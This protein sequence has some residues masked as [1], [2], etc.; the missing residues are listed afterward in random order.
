MTL[1][2]EDASGMRV[3]NLV[4][5][6]PFPAGDNVA[7]W[8]GLDDVGRDTDAAAHATYHIPGKIVAP[9]AYRVR[10]LVRPQIDLRYEMTAYHSGNPPWLTK[11]RSS[12]WLANH[13]PPSAVLYVPEGAAPDRPGHPAPGGQVLVGS[14]VSEGG[15][16]LAWLNLDGKKLNGQEWVGGVWTGATQLARDEGEHPVP[17]VYAYT[18]SAWRG[19]KYNGNQPELRLHM[20]VNGA[21]KLKAPGDTRMGTGEDVPVL[22]PTYKLPPG[23]PDPEYTSVP[24]LGGLAVRNGILVAAITPLDELVFFDVAAGKAIATASIPQPRGLAFD[25]QGRLLAISQK[26]VVRIEMPRF[27]G[28]APTTQAVTLAAPQVIVAS[29]LDDPQQLT[30]DPQGNLYVSDRGDSHQVKVFSPEGKLLRAI[31]AKGPPSVGIYD[32]G[33][34][35]NPNGITIDGRGHLWVAETDNLPKRLSVWTMDGKLVAAF[36][37][38]PHYGGGGSIDPPDPSRFFYADSGGA[39]ELKLDWAK[40]TSAPL[41]VYLRPELDALKEFFRN[42]RSTGPETPVHIEGRTYLTDAYNSNPTGGISTASIWLLKGGRARPVATIGQANDWAAF[43]P[44]ARFSARWTGQ[45]VP[46]FSE[47]YTFTLKA[48]KG[49]RLWVNGKALIDDWRGGNAEATGTL[50]M[51]AGKRYDIRV[52]YFNSGGGASITLGWS[53][54]SQPKQAIPAA[55]LFP[56]DAPPDAKGGSGLSAEYFFDA[57]FKALAE[58]R[59]DPKVEFNWGNAGLKLAKAAPLASKLPAGVDLRKDHVLFA[60]SDLNDDGQ[61][62]PDEITCT[63]DDVLSVNVRQDLSAITGSGLLLKPTRFTPGGAPVYDAG[64]ARKVVEGTQRPTSSGGGQAVLGQ[65]GHFVFTNAPKPFSPNGIGGGKDGRATW[66]YPSLWPGLH[67]SHI[68]PVPEVPGELIGTTRLLGLPVT[69]R[70]SDLGAVW[71][72]NGNK[73][74][75][76]LFTTDGLFVAT[77]FKDSR[78]GSW[79]MPSADRG[80]LVNDA[81]IHEEDFFPSISQTVDGHIYLSV[82]NCCLVRVE[83][84]EKSHRLPDANITVSPEQLAEAQQ[85]FLA[86]EAARQEAARDKGPAE[87]TVA[88]RKTPP[89]VDGSL[90]D[91]RAAQWATIDQRQSQVGDWGR[92]KITTAAALAVAG[93]RLYVALKTDD[94]N[95]LNNSAESLQ[96]LFKTGGCLDLMI[97][98]DPKADPQ[99]ARP[100]AGDERLL[101]TRVKGKTTAVLYRPVAPGT[102]GEPVQF[103]SPL[104]TIKFDRVDDVSDKVTIASGEEKDEKGKPAGAAFEFSIP[105]DVLGLHPAPN[106]AIKA[107]VGVLRGNGFQTLQ[108]AYWSNKATGLVS[109]VPSEA[110]LTPRLWGQWKFAE[111]AD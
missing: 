60:W 95:L 108:R 20:L 14:F 11:D 51:Q 58:R 93:D 23:L 8:D 106:Q 73:G 78:S 92:R 67:A 86:S 29:D 94:P 7:W 88:L 102:A 44:T 18:G 76:Y 69:P 66:S 90:D 101:I 87:L 26:H 62:Q 34:M 2:L 31:G 56:A 3:R 80:M 100:V 107:D 32:P 57:H 41:S 71:A 4:S 98:A 25:R 5:E 1:V 17:G 36:Y 22:K 109:D 105:L 110:E 61:V 39:M 96:N 13:T 72:I 77:L 33:H 89:T 10:G 24:T 6:T 47:Q 104:R 70:G 45:V 74:T 63:A 85:Y 27:A 16:G 30:L 38:P 99:R 52:E 21:N 35:R 82:V 64:N 59:I 50:G 12:G 53:S 111:F 65:D 81:S 97:G 79:S 15:S 42:D 37:G 54:A 43:N 28:A 49:A 19:D 75:I 40:G 48:D 83:G 9:G 84:L 103:S 91:W 46:K 68:A 55:Q